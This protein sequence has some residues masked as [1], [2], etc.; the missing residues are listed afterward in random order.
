MIVFTVEWRGA[1]IEGENGQPQSW[2]PFGHP[3]AGFHSV[4]TVASRKLRQ[5]QDKQGFHGFALAVVLL[6]ALIG[7]IKQHR[8][9]RLQG[10]GCEAYP[11]PG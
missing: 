8:K 3:S 7:C 1:L 10:V 4:D 2:R 5:R 6:A 11:H 9:R